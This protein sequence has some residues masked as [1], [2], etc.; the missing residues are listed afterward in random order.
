M[1]KMLMNLFLPL[2]IEVFGLWTP[3]ARTTI[4]EIA[5]TGVVF[6]G[7]HNLL[8]QLLVGLWLFNAKMLL[9]HHPAQTG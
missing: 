3:F 2:A 7:T 8:Q 5:T 1:L 4:Q 6:N 9:H